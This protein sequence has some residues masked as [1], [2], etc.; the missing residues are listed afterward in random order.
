MGALPVSDE[1][2]ITSAQNPR[3]KEA[4]ALRDRKEREQRQRILV[5]G[6]REIG[7]AIAS[8]WRIDSAFVCRELLSDAAHTL[9]RTLTA[10]RG[11]TSVSAHVFDKLALREGSDGIAVVMQ[12]RS[13]PLADALQSRRGCPPL[14]V[15]LHGIE[16]PGILGAILRTADG[17]GASGVVLL[18]G[19][20]DPLSPNAVRAS[21]G[22]V[23]ALPI[24]IATTDAL[25]ASG[26]AAG[27]QFFAAALGATAR[28]PW[29][30]DLRGPTCLVL[31]AE[32]TGLPEAWLAAADQRILIPMHGIA[33]SLN[34]AAAGAMLLYEA[35]RQRC[36]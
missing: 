32:A 13:T 18:E 3:I 34:V 6:A 1:L 9:L 20:S 10:G 15:A 35:M 4:A 24:A 25:L 16:K 29:Q 31:G 8:G 12:M 26:R 11:I 19:T 14:V 33:D 22:T 21:L 30:H 23:F 17:I 2:H 27:L 7:R 5:E 28:P 36:A